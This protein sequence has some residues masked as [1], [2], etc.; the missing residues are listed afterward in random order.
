MRK[1]H[2]TKALAVVVALAMLMTA[3]CG[4]DNKTATDTA[5]LTPTKSITPTE[6]PK[7]TDEPKPTEELKPTEDPKKIEEG[8]TGDFPTEYE[9]TNMRIKIPFR[10]ADGEFTLDALVGSS[11]T[12]TDYGIFMGAG[13]RVDETSEEERLEFAL[14]DE[15]TGTV[16]PCGYIDDFSYETSGMRRVINGKLYTLVTV[17]DSMLDSA[18]LFLVEI[19]LSEHMMRKIKVTDKSFPYTSVMVHQERLYFIYKEPGQGKVREVVY[20]YD[21]KTDSL[22]EAF[23]NICLDTT[24]EYTVLRSLYS[25]GENLYLLSVHFVND[26]AES[27]KI[28]AFDATW[29]LVKTWDITEFVK[30]LDTSDPGAIQSNVYSAEFAMEY[31][32]LDMNVRMFEVIDGR[33]LHFANGSVT[34]FMADLETREIISSKSLLPAANAEENSRLFDLE[35]PDEAAALPTGVIYFWKDNAL[36]KVVLPRVPEGYI[37]GELSVTP[38][39]KVLCFCNHLRPDGGCDYDNH[40][41]I[42]CSLAEIKDAE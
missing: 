37:P 32:E 31:S 19:D 27:M 10:T 6:A 36:R 3:G 12:M 4:K 26:K 16:T 33:Y 38:N 11:F 14:I 13:H 15:K 17:G 35:I 23:T 42:V 20:C 40:V 21:P 25:D 24:K 28:D 9:L 5:K 39:G 30:A 41:A 7:P 22:T 2:F 8:Q 29:K 34:T 1:N 18:E